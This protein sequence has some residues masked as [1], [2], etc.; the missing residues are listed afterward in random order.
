MLVLLYLFWC[1]LEIFAQET[2]DVFLNQSDDESF[3]VM[4]DGSDERR[5]RKFIKELGATASL[6]LQEVNIAGNVSLLSLSRFTLGLILENGIVGKETLHHDVDKIYS[7]LQRTATDYTFNEWSQFVFGV[8]AAA[9]VSVP[10]TDASKDL[11]LVAKVEVGSRKEYEFVTDANVLAAQS[12]T[13]LPAV[14][15]HARRSYSAVKKINL[16]SDPANLI[17]RYSQGTEIKRTRQHFFLTELGLN[18]NYSALGLNASY[19]LI[20]KFYG[21]ST[22]K[23][24]GDPER[25]LVKLTI[26]EQKM[27]G[28]GQAASAAV[29]FLLFKVWFVDA[30]LNIKMVS[31]TR[32]KTKGQNTKLEY[33]YD[34]AYPQARKALKRA[35]NGDLS[36]T[37]LLSITR[38]E[39]EHYQGILTN[40]DNRQEL[41][42]LIIRKRFGFSINESYERLLTSAV[43]R[44]KLLGSFL[45]D[46]NIEILGQTKL[47]SQNF[48]Q[49]KKISDI[50]S[51]YREITRN[52]FWRARERYNQINQSQ[53]EL[54][55]KLGVKSDL[56][57]EEKKSLKLSYHFEIQIKNNSNYLRKKILRSIEN[58]INMNQEIQEPSKRYF[59]NEYCEPNKLMVKLNGEIPASFFNT[60]LKLS[61]KDYWTYLGL[62]LGIDPPESIADKSTRQQVTYELFVDDS[63][64][65]K[66]LRT[67]KR[68]FIKPMNEIKSHKETH[69]QAEAIRDLYRINQNDTFLIEYLLFLTTNMSKTE[70]FEKMRTQISLNSETCQFDWDL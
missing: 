3:Y 20:T 12:V 45:Y 61:D 58:I 47:R 8:K 39:E 54:V 50:Y 36:D 7:L 67:F 46:E 6:S 43:K 38:A 23:I 37:T 41:E 33:V 69:L 18:Y 64:S 28:S 29:E 44:R 19:F 10:L 9:P 31:A 14:W 24:L 35:I 25:K 26:E 2:P 53:I 49:E 30:K 32:E 22:F 27:R 59:I 48:Y 40:E 4:K 65:A 51:T 60:L 34:L 16:S 63:A 21:Q 11:S 57:L 1:S 52:A 68:K 5:F 15:G 13:L 66:Q 62:M 70:N 55:T 56:G 17:E 42:N